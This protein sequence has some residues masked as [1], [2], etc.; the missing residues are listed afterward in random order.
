MN[1]T[2]RRECQNWK[3]LIEP[4]AKHAYQKIVS[5]RSSSRDEFK[6]RGAVQ[7]RGSAL[8]RRQTTQELLVALHARPDKKLAPG[9]L[10]SFATKLSNKDDARASETIE[11]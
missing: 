3:G 8:P 4:H 10:L 6:R 11:G 7:E 9:S 1:T 5:A 2:S